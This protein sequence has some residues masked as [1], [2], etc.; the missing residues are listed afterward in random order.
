MDQQLGI[1]EEY[2][3]NRSTG[4][5]LE[6]DEPVIQ[7]PWNP[8]DIRVGSKTFSVRNVLDMIDE[9]GLDVAPEFQRQRV[10]KPFQ[11]ARLVESI[12]LQI[13]LPSFYFTEDPDGI[14]RVVD[15]LQR[16]STIYAFTR[17]GEYQDANFTLSDLEYLKEIE[18]KQYSELAPSWQRRVNNTQLVV[19]VIDPQTP[20]PVK[21]DIFRRINTGGTPLNAQ[22]IRHCM[23]SQ[24]SR[25]FLKRLVG[26]QSFNRATGG[27]LH[28]HIRMT[29]REVALRFVAFNRIESI[30]K[31]AQFETMDSF[32]TDATRFID[33]EATEAEL[34][35][36]KDDFDGAM[37]KA[38]TVFKDHAFRKWSIHEES[39]NP[40]NRA[41]FEAWSVC[42]VPY[43]PDAIRASSDRIQSAARVLMTNDPDYLAAISTSTGDARRVRE[44]FDKTAAAIRESVA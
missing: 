5:E 8:D 10:W 34:D 32:L 21:F 16:I 37:R 2:F 27:V 1:Q 44:R 31:Y 12:L 42:L 9:G 18:G 30:S 38:F 41:L 35:S 15:G 11:K 43:D 20:D 29:D 39:R 24:R 4:V 22:E 25:D 28:E 40:I 7:K 23:S 33:R 26:S 17:G 14:L 6:D 3:D 36:L 13:P 19:H